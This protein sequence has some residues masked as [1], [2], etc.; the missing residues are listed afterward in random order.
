METKKLAE[1]VYRMLT[2]QK[3]SDWYMNGRFDKHISGDGLDAPTKEEI[4]KD[5][6]KMLPQ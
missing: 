5:I 1:I 6:E 3:F 4:L 2:K